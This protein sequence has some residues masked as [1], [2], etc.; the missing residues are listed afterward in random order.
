MTGAGV[1]SVAMNDWLC[2]TMKR[3][4]SRPAA[5]VDAARAL[6]P[7]AVCVCMGISPCFSEMVA[8]PCWSF[9]APPT[10]PITARPR[11]SGRPKV[12][13]P[14]PPYVAPRM[15][16]SAAFC[17]IGISAPSQAAQSTGAKLKP[18]IR[19]SPMN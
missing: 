9:S 6:F 12:V 2:A 14:L 18:K 13:E 5:A 7:Y 10:G 11:R 17:E 1:A 15:E 4:G 16:N 3:A 19:I 8:A